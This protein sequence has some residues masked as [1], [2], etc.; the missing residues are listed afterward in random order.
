MNQKRVKRIRRMEMNLDESQ[1]AMEKLAAA[2]DQYEAVQEKYYKLARYYGSSLWLEDYEADEAGQLPSELKRGVLS[3]DGV[4]NLLLE[5][6]DLM[7]RLQKIVL[8]SLEE[9]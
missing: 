3:E 6:R 7:K 5:H 8:R 4:Y 1:K 9:E 2:M